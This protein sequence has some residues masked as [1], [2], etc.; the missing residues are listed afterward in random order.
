MDTNYLPQVNMMNEVRIE[1]PNSHF[2]RTPAEYI[3]YIISDGTMLLNE[4]GIE[5]TLQKGDIILLDPSRCHFGH[6]IN[7]AIQYYYIHFSWNNILEKGLM[8]E[9]YCKVQIEKRS[10]SISKTNYHKEACETLIVPKYCHL[11]PNDFQKI[12]RLVSDLKS[13][14]HNSIEY[15]QS[16]AGCQLITLFVNISRMLTNQFVDTSPEIDQLSIQIISYLKNHFAEKISSD[17]IANHCHNNFDYLNR[18]FKQNLGKTIF[19]Y[20]NEYRI[21]MSKIMLNSGL[22]TTNLIA[23]KCGFCNE[24]YFSKVFKKLVGTSPT[25]FKK[26]KLT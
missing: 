8:A 23:D 7:C 26:E 14:Y 18:K 4:G 25:S 17:A 6:K 19:Q 12:K 10:E 13:S 5:Y 21:E 22:Y 15:R 16:I 24:F 11:E 3:L 9:E 20:L 2:R 1:A